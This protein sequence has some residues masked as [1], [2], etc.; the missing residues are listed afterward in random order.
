[1]KKNHI[2]L[3]EKQSMTH[4]KVG[5]SASYAR[6]RRNKSTGDMSPS[7]SSG[8]VVLTNA[9]C[10]VLMQITRCAVPSNTDPFT[11]T[12]REIAEVFMCINTG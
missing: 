8:T 2:L 9:F 4:D 6:H 5:P 1:M 12:R 10:I 7:L 3:F 11:Y